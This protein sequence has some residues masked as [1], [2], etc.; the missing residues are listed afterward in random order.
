M[1]GI[2]TATVRRWRENDPQFLALM[3]DAE[4]AKKDFFESSL[5]QLAAAGDSGIVKFV[6]E[7][8]NADRGYNRKSEVNH[9]G[10]INHNLNVVSME[11]LA[12]YL[13]F[14][15]KTKILEAM[16]QRDL[17]MQPSTVAGLPLHAKEV[18]DV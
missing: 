15:T 4:N 6:N 7:T 10:S 2:P 13:D 14:D 1:T 12:P 11:S 9:T 18:I 3:K 16:R 5:I 17:A 8:Y